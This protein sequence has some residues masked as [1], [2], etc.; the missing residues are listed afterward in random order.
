MTQ[1]GAGD[2]KK[3][4]ATLSV[5]DTFSILIDNKKRTDTVVDALFYVAFATGAGGGT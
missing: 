4:P 5:A 1:D 3:M 2:I